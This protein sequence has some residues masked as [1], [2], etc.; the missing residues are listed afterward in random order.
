MDM[1]VSR[2]QR[3]VGCVVCT[4]II[5]P[6]NPVMVSQY[7]RTFKRGTRTVRRSS[8]YSCWE[9]HARIWFDEHPYI[10]T[11]K[12]GPGRNP[13]YTEQQAKDR[14]RIRVKMARWLTKQESYTRDGM[15]AMA[16]KYKGL[17]AGG[18]AELNVMI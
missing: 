1:W 9:I 10:P 8:H 2:A 15:W 18:R 4:K 3:R 12:A 13:L 14:Q 11:V 5:E 17:I 16:D 7:K 6:G